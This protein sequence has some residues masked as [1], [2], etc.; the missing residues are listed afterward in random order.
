MKCPLLSR[1]RLLHHCECGLSSQVPA[2]CPVA[3]P[4]TTRSHPSVPAGPSP[5]PLQPP[6]HDVAQ[7]LQVGG[8]E[9]PVVAVAPLHVLLDAV[10]VHRVQVQ[11]L[12]LP[13][14]G[15]KKKTITPSSSQSLSS[16]VPPL[17]PTPH[18][19]LLSTLKRTSSTWTSRG[20]WCFLRK[21]LFVWWKFF[22]YF[23]EIAKQSY[24]I[25]RLIIPI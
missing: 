13:P 14:P 22:F 1:W 10:Q 15:G 2:G 8:C 25:H 18:N 19:P 23:S 11:Q 17:P 5:A 21:F 24:E 12:W 4:S 20:F 9:V 6:A 3:C 7:L 16:E